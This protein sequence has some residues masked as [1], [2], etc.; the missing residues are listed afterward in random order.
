MTVTA[1]DLEAQVGAA[2]NRYAL[3]YAAHDEVAKVA[4]RYELCL[5][6]V[7]SGWCPPP[8]VVEQMERDGAALGR[9]RVIQL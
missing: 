9:S 7:E 5:A 4:A 3:A 1:L 8:V 2:Y 6:L